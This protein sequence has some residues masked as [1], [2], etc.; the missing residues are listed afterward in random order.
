[1]SIV[2]LNEGKIYLEGKWHTVEDITEKINQKMMAKDLKIA[3]LASAL[4]EL[5]NALVNSQSLDLKIVLSKS[6]YEKLRAKGGGNELVCVQKAIMAYIGK[7]FPAKLP[8][9]LKDENKELIDEI[10]TGDQEIEASV[11]AFSKDMD[12]KT[13]QKNNV[14]KC[15]KCK[16][17]I[18]VPAFKDTIDLICPHC[19]TSG[20]I[21]SQN[22]DAPRYVDRYLGQ[23]L[24]EK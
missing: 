23:R 21:K 22:M 3:K 7:E 4:E 17:E 18:E 12:E 11:S 15:F 1:M 8:D 6:D 5:N 20:R 16:A 9:D 19:N 10:N 13:K 24:S 14:I 2:C